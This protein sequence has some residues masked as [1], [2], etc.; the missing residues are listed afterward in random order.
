LN[1]R[2]SAKNSYNKSKSGKMPKWAKRFGGKK[3]GQELAVFE[4]EHPDLRYPYPYHFQQPF[5][6]DDYMNYM[7]DLHR[8]SD[9]IENTE[10]IKQK[11][12]SAAEKLKRRGISKIL[13]V[14]S[15]NIDRSPTAENLF[16]NQA[17]LEVKSAGVSK[18]A[19]KELTPEMIDW[20]DK[21]F[22]MDGGVKRKIKVMLPSGSSVK[23]VSLGIGDFY[24][25]NSDELKKHIL[26]SLDDYLSS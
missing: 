19:F 15:A 10:E 6:L 12:A 13:F 11:V 25:R 26:S 1:Y 3:E 9:N 7:M 16:K 24:G 17:G 5:Q 4:P 22:A 18:T 21:I 8:K 20:A 23:L 14:C 2:A